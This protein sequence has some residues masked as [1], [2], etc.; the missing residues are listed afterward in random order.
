MGTFAGADRGM[1]R[2]GGQKG[3]QDHRRVTRGMSGAGRP[4][5][6]SLG[7][8]LVGNRGRP[9]IRFR[10]AMT[11]IPSDHRAR[12][13]QP[14]QIRQRSTRAYRPGAL[15]ATPQLGAII[16]DENRGTVCR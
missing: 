9:R 14:K 4:L 12:T 16:D 11:T 6:D 5:G 15:A 3:C 8:W 13:A 1:A 2:G 10:Y 7:S